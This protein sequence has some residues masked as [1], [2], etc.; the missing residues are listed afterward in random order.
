M[1]I[2][3]LQ[4][5]TIISQLQTK[6]LVGH[7]RLLNDTCKMIQILSETLQF[8]SGLSTLLANLLSQYVYWERT[9]LDHVL[10]SLRSREIILTN[11][12]WS[13]S[14]IFKNTTIMDLACRFTSNHTEL[15]KIN[16]CRIVKRVIFP[17]ELLTFTGRHP[18]TT[19]EVN[20]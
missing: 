14:R 4:P 10:D 12:S 13:F 7:T 5:S 20:D 11:H 18:T 19:Y 16:L 15:K 3:L 17:F 8:R 9:W 1:G 2:G 6:A